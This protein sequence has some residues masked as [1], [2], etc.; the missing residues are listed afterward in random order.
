MIFDDRLNASRD[1]LLAAQQKAPAMF[2]DVQ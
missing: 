1:L 2:E